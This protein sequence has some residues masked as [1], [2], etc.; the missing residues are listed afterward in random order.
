MDLFASAG[1]DLG[2][3]G[4]GG[5]AGRPVVPR[6]LRVPLF[7]HKV[8]AAARARFAFAPPPELVAVAAGYAKKAKSRTF[9]RQKE[10][11]IRPSF[12]EEVLVGLL[13][14]RRFAAEDVYTLAF[15]R[16][17]RHGAVDVALGRF[18]TPE[19]TDIVWRHSS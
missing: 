5:R 18:G 2:D 9:A 11:A 3:G 7:N 13:G 15:E 17:V 8:I 6:S 4:R 16:P 14:Y 1:I 10:T 19:G 12:F